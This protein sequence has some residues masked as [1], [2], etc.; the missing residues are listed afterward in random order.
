MK[1]L[2]LLIAAVA[3]FAPASL[4]AQNEEDYPIVTEDE[5]S[6]TIVEK[7]KTDKGY[8]LTTTVIDK[9]AVFTNGFWKN[10]EL[11]LGLGVNAYIGENDYKVKNKFEMFAFPAIDAY[12]TKWASPSFGLGLGV[13]G[14]QFKGLYQGRTASGGPL[15]YVRFKTDDRYTGEI[16]PKYG[17]REYEK[18]S[19]QKGN[20]L[21]VFA[22]AHAN[23]MNMFG[24][25]KPDR[26]YTIDA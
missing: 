12:L 17:D 24:G 15:P 11:D 26:F 1:K 16:D 25:Y 23:L 22:L 10:W 7:T 19:V 8:V 13:S 21:N 2:F 6:K 3:F 14:G 20:Y 4:F 5:Y 9:K 18:L